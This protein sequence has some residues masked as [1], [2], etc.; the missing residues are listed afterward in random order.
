MLATVVETKELLETVVYALVAGVGVTIVFS[1]AIYGATR[2]ADL[3]RDERP[4][5]A[6]V[7]AVIA[8]MALAATIGSVVF[9]IIVMTQK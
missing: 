4:A 2:F 5:A 1:L 3:S 9:G 7:A 6:A 8:G